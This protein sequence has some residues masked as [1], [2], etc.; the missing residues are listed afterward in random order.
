MS[1]SNHTTSSPDFN[2]NLQE[3]ALSYVGIDWRIIPVIGKVPPPG[4]TWKRPPEWDRIEPILSQST[5]TGIAVILGEPSGNLVARDFDTVPGYEQWRESNPD[6]SAQLPTSKTQRGFHVFAR[7][8]QPCKTRKFDDGELRGQGSYVVIPPSIHPN[9]GIY[10]W[11]I[12]PFTEIPVIQP[13]LLVGLDQDSSLTHAR[14]EIP[15]LTHAR[16]SD[17]SDED[18]DDSLYLTHARLSSE[19]TQPTKH[20][21]CVR[22]DQLS[23]IGEAINKTLPISF[24]CRNRRVFD[25]ARKLKGILGNDIDQESL[26]A[27]V[28]QWHELALKNINTKGFNETWRDFLVAWSRVKTPTGLGLA[29]I[30]QMADADQYSRPCGDMNGDRIARVFRAASKFH[31][32]REFFMPYRTIAECS[33]FS[34]FSSRAIALRLVNEGLVAIVEPGEPGMGSGKATVWRWIGES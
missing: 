30:K 27:Y 28:E 17:Y 26:R 20:I 6:L 23:L 18:S 8:E 12:S 19:E 14:G 9:G 24:G 5:T 10:Q 3:T 13:L 4:I 21:A 29:A 11:I 15:S 16:Y 25:F 34:A 7:T 1:N 31:G 33:G 32:G 22:Q 2:T